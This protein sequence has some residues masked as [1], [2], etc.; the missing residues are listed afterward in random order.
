MTSW[1]YLVALWLCSFSDFRGISTKTGDGCCMQAGDAYSSWAHGLTP[2]YIGSSQPLL[3]MWWT[4]LLVFLGSCFYWFCMPYCFLIFI[5]QFCTL[6]RDMVLV[7]N[8]F[9]VQYNTTYMNKCLIFI[10]CLEYDL[11]FYLSIAFKNCII[12]L[13][14]VC[15]L[16]WP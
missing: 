6:Y 1:A 9:R 2:L 10:C 3:F 12:G 16:V 14:V 15:V 8:S 7:Q 13:N 4:L 5:Y 11:Q